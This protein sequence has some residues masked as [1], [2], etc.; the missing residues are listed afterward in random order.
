M[1]VCTTFSE[2]CFGVHIE[3]SKKIIIQN[4]D[5]SGT[6]QL[7]GIGIFGG[8]DCKILHTHINNLNDIDEWYGRGINI[9]DS[10]NIEVASNEITM[11]DKAGIAFFSSEASSVTENIIS[12]QMSQG[13]DYSIGVA[14]IT[15]EV[16]MKMNTISALTPGSGTGILYNRSSGIAEA[17]AITDYDHGIYTQNMHG[18]FVEIAL[19]TIEALLENIV[20]N[21]ITRYNLEPIYEG[22]KKFKKSGLAID[23]ANTPHI[24]YGEHGLYYTLFVNGGWQIW[25]IE[26]V[27]IVVDELSLALQS[28]GFPAISYFDATKQNLKYASFDGNSWHIEIIDSEGDVGRSSALLFDSAD[29]PHISYWDKSQGHLKYA[30][31]TEEAWQL[32]T[33]DVSHNVGEYSSLALNSKDLPFITYYDRENT[34]LKYAYQ[35]ENSWITEVLDSENRV[36]EYSSLAIDA[37]DTLHVSYYDF[38]NEDPNEKSNKDLK[39]AHFDGNS[40]AIATI[41]S[42]KDGEDSEG[43]GKYSSLALDSENIPH[44]AYAVYSQSQPAVRY[45]SFDSDSSTWQIVSLLYSPGEYPSLAFDSFDQPHISCYSEV[46]SELKH[47]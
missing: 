34:A 18:Y 46:D 10:K 28:D 31:Y 45:A 3:N 32:S 15:S 36:G 14:I 26:D 44:I 12:T 43:V 42:G 24:A 29:R 9:Q 13:D 35:K 5:I 6:N 22:G 23:G 39:Y 38:G 27:E 11:T 4:L 1:A 37:L 8:E 20:K 25:V 47:I 30:L 16:D 40:W 2:K 7:F 19:N 21:G 17:N 33:V 41:D